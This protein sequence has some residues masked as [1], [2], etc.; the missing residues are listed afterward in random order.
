V[1]GSSSHS[2]A[3]S[4]I[5]REAHC[6]FRPFAASQGP[7]G[8]SASRKEAT[9]F[10][11]SQRL[12]LSYHSNEAGRLPLLAQSSRASGEMARALLTQSGHVASSQNKE[13][14][15][16]PSALRV[17]LPENLKYCYSS[18]RFGSHLGE[19]R[20]APRPRALSAVA[21]TSRGISY[22]FSLNRGSDYLRRRCDLFL[23]HRKLRQRPSFGKSSQTARGANLL[24]GDPSAGAA[25]GGNLLV[26]ATAHSDARDLD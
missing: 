5:D 12:G 2:S 23:G 15:L 25:V 21:H 4:C 22:D 20:L 1:I 8:D 3:P 11:T 10:Q 14:R 7:I 16:S 24:G 13:K 6:R 18:A 17:W 19:C 9:R 26:L